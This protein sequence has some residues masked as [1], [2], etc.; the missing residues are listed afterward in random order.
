MAAFTPKEKT[1]KVELIQR[2]LAELVDISQAYS[3]SRKTFFN[4]S[5]FQIL[6]M[7]RR[8][9]KQHSSPRSQ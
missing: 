1:T 6:A 3:P 8:G 9:L 2:K 5:S 4:I 7:F